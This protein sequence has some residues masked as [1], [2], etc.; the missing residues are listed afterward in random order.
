[1][2][3]IFASVCGKSLLTWIVGFVVFLILSILQCVLTDIEYEESILEN[4]AGLWVIIGIVTAI[5]AF[6]VGVLLV[7][8]TIWF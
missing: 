5:V 2:W 6:A 4:L 7:L 8:I 1:M 3:G